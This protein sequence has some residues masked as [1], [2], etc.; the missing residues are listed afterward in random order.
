MTPPESF[1]RSL[2]SQ[3][4]GRFRVRWSNTRMRWQLEV[5]AAA[6]IIPPAPIDPRDDDLIRAVDGYDFFCEVC[7]GTLTPCEHCGGDLK[8]AFQKFTRVKCER[9]GEGSFA[10]H[11][12]LSDSLLQHIR[13]T[14][15]NRGGYLRI[16]HELAQ[17][18]IERRRKQLQARQEAFYGVL[19]DARFWMHEK[20]GYGNTKAA[21]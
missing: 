21:R 14:D 20:V 10:C 15:P 19:E 6:A 11:W 9:C 12:D 8:A 2:H 13:S 7:P 18:K 17:G 1:V 3:F 16:K 5:K 4:D